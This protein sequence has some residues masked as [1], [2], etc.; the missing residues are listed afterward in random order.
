MLIT[1]ITEDFIHG[2]DGLEPTESGVR[3]HRLSRLVRERYA[4]PQLALMEAQPS[5]A[6][7]TMTTTARSV[8][9]VLHANRVTYRGVKRDRGALDVMIDGTIHTSHTLTGG[10][11]TELDVHTGASTFTPGESDTFTIENLP[12]GEKQ[13]DIWLPHNERV[14]LIALR[15][16][17]ELWPAPDTRPVWLHHGSSI[18]QGFNA[19]SPSRTW[20][21]V[22]AVRAGVQVR[23]LGFG[24]SALVDPFIARVMR[25]TPA[26]LI[27]VKV[28]INVVTLDAMRIRTFVSAVHGFLDTIRDGHPTTPILLVS[29]IYC[30]IHERTPGP[31]A[32]DPTTLS[33]GSVRF[34]AT[35][36]K[37]DAA[38]GRLTLQVVRNALAA[39][40]DRRLDDPNL[41]YLDGL[42][43]YGETDARA[44][45]LP[46]ALHPDTPTHAVIGERFADVV[47]GKD[48]AFGEF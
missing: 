35:G 29:P 13:I 36:T 42:S 41:H 15:S 25:D 27:S 5:G 34:L 44:H 16:D 1:P 26:S 11:T 32:F 12:F 14:D 40:V 39:I 6:R 20:P 24:S 47:F 17:A 48:G 46:D 33:G 3:L 30:G 8:T 23:N 19:T 28:G 31:A 45:P 38:N 7:I 18:S 10:D 43:L 9:L 4:D 22:A 37:E 2:V 21:A